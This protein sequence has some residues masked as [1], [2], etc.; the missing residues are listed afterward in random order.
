MDFNRLR[1][2]RVLI[3]AGV[4]GMALL[5]ALGVGIG[6][7]VRHA[8]QPSDAERLELAES[9]TSRS[10]QLEMGSGDPGLDLTKPLRC[11]VG[12]QYVGMLTLKDCATR[13]GIAPGQ[14]DVGIDATGAVAAASDAAAVLQPLPAAPAAPAAVPPA[15]PAPPPPQPSPLFTG[16]E[17]A[18]P[19]GDSGACWRYSGDWRKVGEDLSLDACVQA[20]FAGKCVR[21]GAADYGRWGETTVRLVA[22]K[23]ERQTSGGGFRT[24]VRQPPGDC[25]IPYAQE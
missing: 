11:F 22:G 9:S 6:A 16:P 5:A 8:A 15:A 18:A 7:L 10:L 13:N 2:P 17:A 23:V 19:A 25:S 4:G 12:G 24:L 20:L 3:A 14:L 1:D 21:P